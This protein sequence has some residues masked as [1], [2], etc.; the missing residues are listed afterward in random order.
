LHALRGTIGAE[1]RELD[2]RDPTAMTAAD[3][4]ALRACWDDRHLLIVPGRELAGETLSGEQQLAFVGRFGRLLSEGRPWGYVSNARPDG[5]VREGAQLFHADY[6]FT[7]SPIDGIS[8]HAI[9]MPEDGCPTLFADACAAVDRLS[10]ELRHRL[11]ELQVLNCYDFRQ[12]GDEHVN[13]ADLLPG[14]PRHTHPVI[15]P[16][17]RT[18]QAVIFANQQQS[19]HLIGVEPEAGAALLRELFDVL[20]D[21][22]H[23]YEHRWQPGDLLLWDNIALHHGR[24]RPPVDAARTLQRVTL[25]AYTP[26]ELVPNLGQLLAD[27]RAAS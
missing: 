13:E 1:V 18:G 9:E 21:P 2:L 4:D 19:D 27:A 16:H 11:A 15:G 23:V 26:S 3:V 25:G 7:P 10:E 24:M 6:A 22:A 5:V 14:M 17:P 20:Y 8:L 12:I